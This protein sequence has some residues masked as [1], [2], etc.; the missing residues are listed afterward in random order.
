MSDASQSGVTIPAVGC[1]NILHV[2]G[3]PLLVTSY[4]R[5]LTDSL[6]L[7]R[8]SRPVAVDFAN[9]QVVTLRRSETRFRERT[10][11]LDF[12]L[13]DGMPLVWCLNRQGAGLADRVYGPEF[14]RRCLTASPAGVRHYLLGGSEEC[15]ARLRKVIRGWNPGC[16]VVGWFHGRCDADGR[17]DPAGEE[18][19]LAELRRLEP[20]YIWVGLGTPKQQFWM[21]RCRDRL[22]RGLLLGVGFAFDLHAGLK[23]D[24][25]MWMQRRGLTW[26]FRMWS[27]PLRLGPRYL[28]FNTLFL[29]YL[30]ADGLRGRAFAPPG[31][32]H[33]KR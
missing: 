13:P 26:I 25:P 18:A 15:G 20:D 19:L 33:P 5:F 4:D 12:Y 10:G 27:E 31:D 24:A 16:E 14:T 23:P 32:S 3:T 11:H 1:G 8:G 17:M 30:L 2:L 29:A 21:H 6:G 22:E 7:A 28:R 9:T